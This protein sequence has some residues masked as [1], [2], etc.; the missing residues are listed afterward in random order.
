MADTSPVFKFDEVKFQEAVVK[1]EKYLEDFVGKKGHNP[2]FQINEL[3]KLRERY[4]KGERSQELF[5]A[6]MAYKQTAPAFGKQPEQAK[7]AESP[8]VKK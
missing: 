7:Q 3:N 5:N 6:A 1:Q 2:F 4:A 8:A